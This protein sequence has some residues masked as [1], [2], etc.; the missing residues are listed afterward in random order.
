MAAKP[1][2]PSGATSKIIKINV[3]GKQYH[4][5]EATLSSMGDNYITELLTG[6]KPAVIDDEGY[7]F[8]GT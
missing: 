4:T 3:G 1:Q 5:T 7:Y 2:I 6:K 8:I